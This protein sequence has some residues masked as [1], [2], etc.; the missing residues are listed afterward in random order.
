MG[1]Y[2]KLLLEIEHAFSKSE[3]PKKLGHLD[4]SLVREFR[5]PLIY[6]FSTVFKSA[7]TCLS[8]FIYDFWIMPM[9]GWSS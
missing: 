9:S 5:T 7:L 3:S 8:L 2:P 4:A 1:K 6:F